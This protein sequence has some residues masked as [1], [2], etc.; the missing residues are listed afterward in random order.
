VI[1]LLLAMAG[2][3]ACRAVVPDIPTAAQQTLPAMPTP[4]RALGV[5]VHQG[6]IYAA[7]GWNGES[8]Q[9]SVV[10]IYDPAQNLWRTGPDLPNPRS[11]HSLVSAGDHLWIVGGWSATAGLVSAVDVLEDPAGDWR[12]VAHL[13]APRR[14]PGVVLW[15]DEIVVAGGFDGWNDADMDGYSARVDA[16]DPARNRWR[17]LASLQQPRRGLSLVAIDS[18]LYAIGGYG[19]GSPG[20]LNT[21]E[22]YA[23]AADRWEV[24]AWP[25]VARTWAG[26][27]ALPG[28][29]GTDLLIAGGY[30]QTGFLDL[31][32]RIDPRT[33]Q[34]CHP[35]PLTVARAWFGAVPTAETLLL[36]GGETIGGFTDALTQETGECV[37]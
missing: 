24:V 37:P 26:A 35:P 31:V 3:G 6:Q 22:R 5:A 20:F 28:A 25:I 11:Q 21:V 23:A 9:L 12:T 19:P 15:G 29:A 27:V 30:N 1:L 7:G 32:E 4:R 36:M 17:R 8:T 14:E 13:P 2:P 18:Q 33:G 16:Y 10:E 34:I